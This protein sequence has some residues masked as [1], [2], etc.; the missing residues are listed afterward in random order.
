MDTHVHFILYGSYDDTK[1]TTD[2]DYTLTAK[3]FNSLRYNI[4]S[5]KVSTG[6][7]EKKRGDPVLGSYFITLTDCINDWIDL[8]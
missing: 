1:M 6:I 4:G 5:R 8:L 3:K 2:G 7:T